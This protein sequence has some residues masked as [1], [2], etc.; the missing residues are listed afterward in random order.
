MN[1]LETIKNYI[2]FAQNLH[3]VFMDENYLWNLANE[4]LIG[5]AYCKAAVE[6]SSADDYET[7]IPPEKII[8]ECLIEFLEEICKLNKEELPLYEECLKELKTYLND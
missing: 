5:L 4:S 6:Y 1:I 2:V 7:Q 8:L 3:Q